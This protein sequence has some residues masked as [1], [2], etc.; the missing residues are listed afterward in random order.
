MSLP[1][2]AIVFDI[3]TKT[4]DGEINPANDIHRIT[5]MYSY[6]LDKYRYTINKTK[7]QEWFDSHDIIIGHNIKNYDMP[8]LTRFGINCKW[9]TVIDTVEIAR[10]R[11]KTLLGIE[12][13]NSLK[14]LS[15]LFKFPIQKGEIDYDIFQKEPHEWTQEEKDEIILYLKGDVE[16]SRL[17]FEKLYDEFIEFRQF[18]SVKNQNNFSWLT[19]TSGSLSYKVLCNFAGLEEEYGQFVFSKKEVGGG[20]VLSPTREEATDVWYLDFSSEYPWVNCLFNLFGNPTLC[21]D[22]K[23]WF[24]GNDVFKVRG[25]YSLD[26]PHILTIKTL[27][28]LSNRQKVKQTNPKLANAYKIVLNGE[29]GVLRSKTFKSTYYEHTGYDCAY[30]GRQFNKIIKKFF[31]KV[32]FESIYGDTDSRFL[33]YMGEKKLTIE[34]QYKLLNKT[35]K[36]IIDYIMANVPF[37]A[38]GFDLE[39]ETGKEPIKYIKF[40]KKQGT[41]EY[42][43]KN[44]L[45]LTYDGKV[46]ITGLPLIKRGSTKVSKVVFDKWLKQKIIEKGHC[47]FSES[48]VMAIVKEELQK[49]LTLAS[50]EYRVKEFNY[51]KNKNDLR[52]KISKEFFE[53]KWGSIRLIKNKYIGKIKDQQG[54]CYCTED[55]IDKLQ[56]EFLELD[57]IKTELK[58]FMKK[59]QSKG[60]FDY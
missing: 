9:K 10:K 59:V 60:V 16:C 28:M 39:S 44:Y 12:T 54:N 25:K 30:L 37:P 47:N 11:L 55:E 27:E 52:A 4:F 22:A 36:E 18:V 42:A 56:V 53:G 29:Y 32:N 14:E 48:K 24:T 45:Y 5:G 1:I 2:N 26:E 19:A 8:I 50:M 33:K 41:E 57:K 21:P 51:Y 43:K 40:V 17:L 23:E 7:I 35:K 13:G 58:P 6:A 15:K 49:D 31:D 38:K 20:L 3:E 46:K 34:E